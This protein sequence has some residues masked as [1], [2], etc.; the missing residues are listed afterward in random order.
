MAVIIV[1]GQAKHA[2]KTTLVCNIIAAFPAVQWNAIKLTGHTHETHDCALIRRGR[3]WA[4]WEQVSANGDSDTGR[5]LQAGAARA[6]LIEADE[7]AAEAWNTAHELLGS[8]ADIIAEST[9]AASFANSDLTLLLLEAAREEMK[10][11]AREQ[12]KTASA[13]VWRGVPPHTVPR[14]LRERRGFHSYENCVDPKLRSLI[15]DALDRSH[16]SADHKRFR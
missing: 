8:A 16:P 5:F 12:V 10:T 7:Q 2:G 6:F 13:I 14:Q 9:R 15:A 1:G 3:D 4:I 11:S